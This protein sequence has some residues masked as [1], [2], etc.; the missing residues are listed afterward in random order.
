VGFHPIADVPLLGQAR[1][2]E[3]NKPTSKQSS[4]L[5]RKAGLSF[6]KQTLVPWHGL[7]RWLAAE[8]K[9]IAACHLTRVHTLS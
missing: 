9:L 5:A 6:V 4:K 8:S 3:Q 7:P 1:I 2:M